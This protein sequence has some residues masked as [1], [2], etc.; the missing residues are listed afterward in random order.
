MCV[1]LFASVFPQCSR[2]A[3]Q[4]L[5]TTS[6][7]TQRQVLAREGINVGRCECDTCTPYAVHTL[8]TLKGLFHCGLR[9]N[10]RD[11]RASTL[12]LRATPARRTPTRASELGPKKA[13][14]A[15]PSSSSAQT[16]CMSEKLAVVA[17]STPTTVS[18]TSTEPA[19]FSPTSAA[20]SPFSPMSTA[21]GARFR[22]SPNSS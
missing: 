5:W 13:V 3:K 9:G 15:S 8:Q 17:P 2:P 18:P 22:R 1:N 20:H 10:V 19:P 6:V 11:D 14:L 16:A 4:G 21:V 12:F 7:C